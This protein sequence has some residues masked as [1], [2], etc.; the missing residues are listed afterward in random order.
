V[1]SGII[2][3]S[4]LPKTSKW[5]RYIVNAMTGKSN[6][7]LILAAVL[8]AFVPIAINMTILHIAIPPMTLALNASGSQVLWIIDIYPLIMAGLL[9]PMGALADRVG[10]RRLLLSGLAI[11]L[12]ASVIAAYAS[13]TEALIG[14]RA[15]LAVGGAMVLPNVLAIIRQTFDDPREMGLALGLWST[16]ASA[17]AAVGPLA[18]GLL[19]EHFW[20]GAVFLMNVPV[21]LAVW[22][23][24][25][26]TLPSHEPEVQGKWQLGQALVFLLGLISTIYAMKAGFNVDNRPVLSWL[27]AGMGLSLLGWFVRLQL[28]SRNPMLDLQLFSTP[29]VS[30][31][32]VTAMVV[33]GSLAGIEMT[34]A[35]ELQFIV[36][37]TPLQAG[38]FLLPLILASAI[39]GPIVGYLVSIFGLRQ[40]AALSLFISAISLGGL[41]LSDFAAAGVGVV[42]LLFLLGLALGIGLTASSVAIMSSVRPEKA[43][44][45]GSL[46]GTGY[47]LGA[48]L[49]ITLFGVLLSSSYANSLRL[50]EHLVGHLPSSATHS[51]G[52]TI[53]AARSIGLDDNVLKGAIS[54]A[55]SSAH[56]TVLLTGALAFGL[57]GITVFV[58]LRHYKP[59]EGTA[60]HRDV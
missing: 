35:Q 57:V 11:F 5:I 53:A 32:V 26:I 2:K 48:G 13:T 46:E 50:P 58:A 55:F 30:M 31:G 44:V 17:G 38:L 16:V 34:I 21:I 42:A 37:L 60:A 25:F 10:H 43:G 24:V 4:H 23:L 1:T 41:G 18:G 52:E 15:L 56:S 19:L 3:Y 54:A 51:V 22:L 28:R 49:G 47:E 8:M 27:A 7:W 12:M 9:V 14:A 6:R 39:G 36:G 33:S 29:A 59:I 45:A 40:V 20:W